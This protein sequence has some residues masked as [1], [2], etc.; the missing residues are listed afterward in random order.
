MP[1]VQV[2][3]GKIVSGRLQDCLEGSEPYQLREL[4]RSSVL[5]RHGLDR[6]EGDMQRGR[7]QV[8]QV[9]RDL[10]LATYKEPQRLDAGQTTVA[11]PHLRGD[12]PGN[13]HVGGVE[14][15]VERDQKRTGAYDHSTR[16]RVELGR[17]VVRL[18]DRVLYAG[19]ETL[20]AALADVGQ[21]AP[22]GSGSCGLVEVDGDSEGTDPLPRRAG[23]PGCV[24]ERGA[25][26]GDEG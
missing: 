3:Q 20:V 5:G 16:S 8:G 11:L 7:L 23:E 12:C 22:V 9:H 17:T 24:I 2:A 21:V 6:V 1:F 19:G 26:E 14:V 15:G 18:P 10:G 25:F 13:A 4:H